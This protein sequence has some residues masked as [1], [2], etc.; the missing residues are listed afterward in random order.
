MDEIQ[1]EIHNQDI[2]IVISPQ[3]GSKV[4]DY[5]H[6]PDSKFSISN[7][8]NDLNKNS[9]PTTS[10]EKRLIPLQINQTLKLSNKGIETSF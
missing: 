6:K 5:N 8:K 3:N 7:S 10:S 2:Q 1:K 4:D 9:R